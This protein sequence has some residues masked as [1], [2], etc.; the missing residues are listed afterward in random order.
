MTLSFTGIGI[1][2]FV[3]IIARFITRA[4]AK[5]AIPTRVK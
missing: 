4:T 3:A 1:I 2:S 5:T